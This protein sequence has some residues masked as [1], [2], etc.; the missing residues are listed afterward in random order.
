MLCFTP[1]EALNDWGRYLYGLYFLV[2]LISTIAY[3]DIVGKNPFE[4]VIYL[5]I[6]RS[7]SQFLWFYPQLASVSSSSNS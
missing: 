3:G 7:M 4:E 2:S 1:I 5:S 6:V